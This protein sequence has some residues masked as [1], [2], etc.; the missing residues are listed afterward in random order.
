MGEADRWEAA[1][2]DTLAA[3]RAENPTAFAHFKRLV[4]HIA[5]H[6]MPRPPERGRA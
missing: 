5:L 3:F 2:A 1:T 6:P 4:L